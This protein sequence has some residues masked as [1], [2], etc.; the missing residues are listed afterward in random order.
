MTSTRYGVELS[1]ALLTKIFFGHNECIIAKEEKRTS[2][3]ITAFG[4]SEKQ[5]SKRFGLSTRAEIP[6]GNIQLATCPS[7]IEM[8]KLSV[9]EVLDEFNKT[10]VQDSD[11]AEEQ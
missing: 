7:K 1:Y 5:T 8:R 9:S 11:L 10:S 2:W 4:C 3:P 6:S